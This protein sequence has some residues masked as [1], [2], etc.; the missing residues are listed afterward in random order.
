MNFRYRLRMKELVDFANDQPQKNIDKVIWR[1]EYV[2]RHNGTGFLQAAN[3]RTPFC[4][5]CGVPAIVAVLI[6]LSLAIYSLTK[7]YLFLSSHS[8]FV[9]IKTV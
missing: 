6:L 9:K 2:L 3:V 1:L 4:N 8:I 5:H 7:L